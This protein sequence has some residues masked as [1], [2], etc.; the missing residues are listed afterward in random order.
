MVGAG[1]KQVL[2]WVAILLP[3]FMISPGLVQKLYGARDVKTV[4]LGVGLNSLGQAVF[5]FVPPVLGLCAFAALPHLA[6]P[7]LALPSAA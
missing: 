3:S 7:E 5:A 4:R 6:N 1:S 2:A